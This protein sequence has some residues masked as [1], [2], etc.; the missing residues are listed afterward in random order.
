[1][2]AT[3]HELMKQNYEQIKQQLRNRE[4][5]SNSNSS[6]SR[7]RVR[8][9]RSRNKKP[10]MTN[11]NYSSKQ[12]RNVQC[13]DDDLEGQSQLRDEKQLQQP[14]L[15]LIEIL[16]YFCYRFCLITSRL[17]A[18]ALL[19]YLF[20][21]WLFAALAGH[22]VLI[23][24]SSFMCLSTSSPSSSVS[25]LRKQMSLF[26]VCLLG[27]VDL[28]ANQLT[29]MANFRK[30]IAYYA[31]CFVQNV[32]VC[33]YWLARTIIESRQPD[34]SSSTSTRAPTTATSNRNQQLLVKQTATSFNHSALIHRGAA[35]TSSSSSLVSPVSPA[36]TTCY[37]TLVYLCIILFTTFGLILKFLHL[38]ILRKRYRR[39]IL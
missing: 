23:Y 18:L 13:E 3:Y 34:S 36:T 15:G 7:S 25:R 24:L 4:R 11:L 33:S 8:I 20:Q 26:V 1:M 21:Q 5:N 19:C 10:I 12:K 30:V 39:R 17:A 28:F 16:V 32:V 37:A 2:F 35:A 27:F 9:N 29:E 22:I 14:D 38:H 6:S 31:L